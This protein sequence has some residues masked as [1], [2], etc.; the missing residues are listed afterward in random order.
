[1]R[2]IEHSSVISECKPKGTAKQYFH[3]FLRFWVETLCVI[4]ML[5]LYVNI[6][7]HNYL[8]FRTNL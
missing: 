1:M 5:I 8:L 7:V 6:E 2:V 4:L 3:H